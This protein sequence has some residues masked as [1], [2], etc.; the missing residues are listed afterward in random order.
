MSIVVRS[1]HAKEEGTT[2]QMFREVTEL[3][4]VKFGVCG[5][6]QG[7]FVIGPPHFTLSSNLTL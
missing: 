5:V 7:E 2:L 6:Q 1:L 3:I 4:L